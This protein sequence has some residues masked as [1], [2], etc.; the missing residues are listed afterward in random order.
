MEHTKKKEANN[1]DTSRRVNLFSNVE[2][3]NSV[4]PVLRSSAVL[5]SNGMKI[6]VGRLA[7]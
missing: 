3:S 2:N 1:I 7:L 4:Y 5:Y 6:V